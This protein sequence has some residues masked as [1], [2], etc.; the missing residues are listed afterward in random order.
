[1]ILQDKVLD[2]KCQLYS[3][4]PSA[5]KVNLYGDINMVSGIPWPNMNLMPKW[6]RFRFLDASVSRSYILKVKDSTLKDVH[7]DVCKVIG[8]DGG[9]RSDPVAIPLSGLLIG[10]A[11]R[12]DVV[13]D[14]TSFQSQTL[15]L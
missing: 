9:Y 11:E 3:D 2:T 10:V 12:Y 1:M 4:I 14:F 15:Y 6:Y 7:Q 13:C 8:N 5:H